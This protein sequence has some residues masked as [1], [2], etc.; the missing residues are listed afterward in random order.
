MPKT[1]QVKIPDRT[2]IKKLDIDTDSTLYWDHHYE[3][4]LGF[5]KN[6]GMDPTILKNAVIK[7]KRRYFFTRNPREELSTLPSRFEPME[8]TVKIFYGKETY[9][10][11][12]FSTQLCSSI[13][14]YSP[15]IFISGT[16]LV[17]IYDSD[18]HL[19]GEFGIPFAENLIYEK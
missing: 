10:Y 12:V 15:I 13:F 3:L 4:T 11:K 5:I 19:I 1:F 6:L 14:L 17:R 8:E 9:E 18:N 2:H 16:T 7:G